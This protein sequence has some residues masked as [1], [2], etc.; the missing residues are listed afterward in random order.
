MSVINGVS[1]D[2]IHSYDDFGMWLSARPDLGSPIPKTNAIDISGADGVIDLTEANTGEVKFS[3][4]TIKLVFA[5]MV[6]VP[7]QESFKAVIM[8]AL[9]G[10]I[11]RQ[12]ILDEDPEWYYNGRATVVFTNITPWKLKCEITIDAAPYATKLTETAVDMTSG[13]LLINRVDLA[14]NSSSQNW[15]SDFRLGTMEFPAGL[16]SD[17]QQNLVVSWPPNP[18][19]GVISRKTIQ[20]ADADGNVYNKNFQLEDYPDD[21][22]IEIPYTEIENNG[23]DVD[24]IYRVLVQNVGDCSL[25]V[26]T[27][28]IKHTVEN[29]RKTVLPEFSLA[30]E[31]PVTINVNGAEHTIEVGTNT[32]FDVVLGHG[33]NEIFIPS[34]PADV[35][36]FTMRFREGKL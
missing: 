27:Q 31:N 13:R 25:Y 16:P 22:L 2:G 34:L 15:N 23:V 17:S 14:S 28:S 19:V 32:Y 4:R 30:A 6:D 3:N 21:D 12:L 35:T 18:T 5:A 7:D 24:R 11:V 36:A 10:K 20:I 26:Q 33:T 9:H 1:F 29:S 8:N